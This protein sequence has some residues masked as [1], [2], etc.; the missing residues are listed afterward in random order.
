MLGL[1]PNLFW[2]IHR[3]KT[4]FSDDIGN[5]KTGYGTGFWVTTLNGKSVFITNKHNVDPSIK[6][7]NKPTY[8]L[9]RI[10]IELR[11]YK[12]DQPTEDT[13]FFEIEDVENC[14]FSSSTAD[15]SILVEPKFYKKA[16][17]DPN[18]GILKSENLIN[19]EMF[20]NSL[21]IGP[22]E[23]SFFVGFPGQDGRH[24]WDEKWKLPIAR[25]CTVASLP[26]IPFTNDQI[27]TDDV[28]LVSGLSFSGSSGSP[29]FLP[30]R[31]FR[32]GGDFNDPTWRPAMLA[33]IMSGHF[34]EETPGPSE[35]PVPSMFRHTGL[36]YMTRSTSILKLIREVFK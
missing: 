3:I 35:T 18:R 23:T 26:Q 17:S 31:G 13:E 2:M 6:F 14:L 27:K 29:V 21:I 30:A 8:R 10:S 28:I 11:H 4:T 15:C 16:P 20:F 24:W 9:D 33:G 34:W 5:R 7:P 25:Q 1:N 22:M 12:S 32:P 19:A 36:S